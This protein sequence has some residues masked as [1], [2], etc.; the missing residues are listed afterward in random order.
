MGAIARSPRTDAATTAVV[1]ASE[2]RRARI[3][4]A[5]AL[6][7]EPDLYVRVEESPKR[8][9]GDEGADD[10]VVLHLDAVGTGELTLIADLK[11]GAPELPIVVVCD[12][13]DRRNARRVVDAGVDGLVFAE[14]LG[15]A[16]APTVAAVLAGQTAIPRVLRAGLR[17]PSLSF[18]EKQ[19]LG[20]VV[21][22]FTNSEIAS[23]LFVAES[24]VKSHLSA[25]FRK[26]GV[27]SRNEAASLILDPQGSLGPGIL[28]ITGGD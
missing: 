27:Q 19:V 2:D 11:R 17:R 14:Q 22:G 23:R 9:V 5:A 25:A 20:M 16:L 7:A 12:C 1:I 21:M 24:T 3:R 15:Y 8:L 4:L 10:L 28:A 18:R 13:T 26:L 6:A